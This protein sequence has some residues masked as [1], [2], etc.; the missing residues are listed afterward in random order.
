MRPGPPLRRRRSRRGHGSGWRRAPHS[1]KTRS[2]TS[3]AEAS[4]VTGGCRA[5]GSGRG[6]PALK[7]TIGRTR[8]EPPAPGQAPPSVRASSN[9]W[10]RPGRSRRVPPCGLRRR[11]V[12]GQRLAVADSNRR[13]G[14]RWL[15]RLPATCAVVAEHP[16]VRV[17][18]LHDRADLRRIEPPNRSLAVDQDRYCIG[19]PPCAASLA[20]SLD[21][22]AWAESTREVVQGEPQHIEACRRNRGTA[23]RGPRGHGSHNRARSSS[24]QPGRPTR[25]RRYY[26]A[27]APGA[28]TGAGGRPMALKRFVNG[29]AGEPS[30]R[31]GRRTTDRHGSERSRCRSPRAGRRTRSSSTRRRVSR[32][33][34]R[35][36]R[37]ESPRSAQTIWI[38]RTS[39]RWTSTVPGVGWSQIRD[40]AMVT[41]R[42]ARGGRPHRLAQDLRLARHP[43]QRPDRAE[44]D[45]PEVRRTALAIAG[46]WRPRLDRDLEVVEGG[47]PRGVPRLQPERQGSDGRVG[48]LRATAARCSRLGR[49]CRGTRSRRSGRGVHP[50]DGAGPVCGDRRSRS[51][52][53]RCGRVARGGAGALA[54]AR[55]RGPGAPCRELP[56]AGGR[57]AAR[58]AVEQRRKTEDDTPEAEAEREKNRAAMEKRF[59]AEAEQR[60]AA[61]AGD[62][63]PSKPTPTGRR[64]SSVP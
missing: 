41:E 55:G 31:S 29:A 54:A 49:R 50:A 24:R 19:R 38:T 4:D 48:L 32:I 40:V 13:R 47:A 23:G 14:R 60:A 2:M 26:L 18:L 62:T 57:A 39:C 43:H 17:V 16:G 59:L 5:G 37:P 52:H 53:R 36:H 9:P 1:R 45:L 56:E 3:R 35:L 34:P 12:G 30:S 8:S 64:R 10:P 22:P 63:D 58:P 6:S 7:S 21:E 27:V 15:Q 44:V 20:A 25:P 42:I 28:L 33:E 51:G 61:S 11:A 46:T